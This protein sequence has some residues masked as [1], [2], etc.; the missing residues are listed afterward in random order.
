[1]KTNYLEFSGHKSR[2]VKY[3]QKNFQKNSFSERVV[4]SI[5]NCAWVDITLMIKIANCYIYVWKNTNIYS[6]SGNIGGNYYEELG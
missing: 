1:M 2:N 5:D 3:I 6:I 4:L